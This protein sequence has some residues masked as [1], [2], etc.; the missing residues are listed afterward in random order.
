[1]DVLKRYVPFIL[2]LDVFLIV[3]LLL[4]DTYHRREAAEDLA[5]WREATRRL[6]ASSSGGDGEAGSSREEPVLSCEQR[7][8]RLAPERGSRAL[9]YGPWTSGGWTDFYGAPGGQGERL[10]QALIGDQVEV[11]S[12]NDGWSEVRIQGTP[13]PAVW[14]ETSHL[15][16]GSER[17]RQAWGSALLLSV[18]KAPGIQVEDGPFLPFSARLAAGGLVEGGGSS[19]LLPNGCKVIFDR[20]HRRSFSGPLSIHEALERAKDFR[21]V[22]YQTGANTRHAMDGPGLVFLVF[23]VAGEPVPRHL[24][25]LRQAGREV[26]IASAGPGDVLFLSTFDPERPQPVILLDRGETYLA[27]SPS[28]GVGL[29]LVSQ[30]HN[31][32][33][34]TVRRYL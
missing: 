12:Q 32:K 11:L 17:I 27:A 9:V 24:D 18:V 14:L 16:A 3:T 6:G 19:L 8:P 13:G 4:F 28:I 15:T 30:M 33:V 29:G 7:D 2:L 31:R 26:S 10:G 34:L 21:R 5:Q 20:A 22:P 23:R 25:E 1:M